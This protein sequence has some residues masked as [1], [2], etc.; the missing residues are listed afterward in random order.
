MEIQQA[1]QKLT[2]EQLSPLWGKSGWVVL[3]IFLLLYFGIGFGAGIFV[4]EDTDPF[5]VTVISLVANL[6]ATFGSVLL[7]G[8]LYKHYSLEE[9]GIKA[10]KWRWIINAV[11]WG[12]LLMF[13][14]GVLA[15][16]LLNLVPALN[17][18]VET[19]DNI[20]VNYNTTLLSKSILLIA[21]S[22]LVPIGE[23]LFFRG[24]LHRWIKNRLH[25][26]PA[27]IVSGTIFAAFHV[28]PIQ[29][30][31]ALPLGILTA[32]MFERSKSLLPPIFLHLS[33]N[34]IALMI[35]TLTL[36]GF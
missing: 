20:F 5:L 1:D 7:V 21:G 13:A 4:N 32:W 6:V 23:E 11:I 26:W 22:I 36:G 29:A 12:I 9:L 3:G 8:M 24:F 2:E 35:T 33:N 16:L 28:I 27:I 17:Y 25:Y 10:V 19:L 18:G 34:F 15:Q 31:M 14:R 30:L